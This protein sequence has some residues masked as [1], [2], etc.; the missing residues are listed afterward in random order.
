MEGKQM[1]EYGDAAMLIADASLRIC[2]CNPSAL[3]L[4][5]GA[6][7]ESLNGRRLHEFLSSVTSGACLLLRDETPLVVSYGQGPDGMFY[8]TLMPTK[9]TAS[10]LL[11][12]NKRL[13]ALVDSLVEVTVADITRRKD[14]ESRLRLERDRSEALLLSVLPLGE[15]SFCLFLVCSHFCF[16]L[17]LFSP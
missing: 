6:N 13:S 16:Y 3:R 12:E 14:L 8:V 4:L 2:H 9:T 5:G 15:L 17:F 1:W 10:D 7:G 11:E